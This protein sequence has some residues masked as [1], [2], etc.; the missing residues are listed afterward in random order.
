MTTNLRV[1]E[2]D[3][4]TIKDNL[5]EF[6]RQKPEF[7][8]YDFD[9]SGL[10]VIMD[11]LA[12][13][14]HYNAVIANM[15]LQETFLDTATKRQSL[16]LIAKRLGYTPK[17][18]R[19]ARA[20]VSMEVFDST[21]PDSITLPFDSKF[22]GSLDVGKTTTFT[23]RQSYTTNKSVD[24]RYIF[25]AIEVFEG[26]N[27]SFRYT[28]T[29]PTTQKFEIPSE[30][31]DTT[32]I[33][34]FVQTSS[35]NST[36]VE[37]TRYDTAHAVNDVTE[38]YFIQYNENGKYEVYFGDGVIG[39][40]IVIGNIIKIDYLVTN[41]Q[42]GNNVKQFKF[43]DSDSGFSNTLVTTLSPSGGGSF[44]ESLDSLRRNAQNSVLMQN[45]AVTESDYETM[46]YNIFAYESVS[47]FGGETMTPPEYGKVFISIKQKDTTA[48]LTQRQKED[49]ISAIKRKSI[50]A[51]VHEVID[52]EYVYLI[53][54]TEVKFDPTKTTMSPGALKSEIINALQLYND[55]KLNKFNSEF[56][57]SDMVTY[58][59]NIEYSI[60]SNDTNVM[61][62]KEVPYV[63]YIDNRYIFNFYTE[64]KESNSK[65]LNI[66]SSD[67]KLADYPEYTLFLS[68]NNGTMYAYY[69]LN[70]ERVTLL[71][72]VGTVDYMNGRISINLKT[73]ITD[74][75]SLDLIVVPANR[76]VLPSR[77]NIITLTDSDISVSIKAA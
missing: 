22:T 19:A 49:I 20:T 14:T 41:G 38:A 1:A 62:R 72:N 13:N 68:D 48:A 71:D 21:F 32:T 59:D 57:Y 44:P 37:W 3:F 26:A 36:T 60:M 6:L 8:D 33:R 4:D 65:E 43:A 12:Y 5:R 64:I 34:V 47:I 77:N 61:M 39:K 70:S 51:I 75:T 25:D 53:V 29:N 31:V 17:G 55:T 40:S 76:N 16:G 24:N 50:L 63:H 15:L 10:S 27:Y 9:G 54:D 45:R 67:F 74:N 56:E 73:M 30:L 42:V 69:I 28:V 66:T 23:T 18:N 11:L 7:T 35:T 52:P 2:L 58:I 46:L